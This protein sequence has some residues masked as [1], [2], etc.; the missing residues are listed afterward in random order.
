[1]SVWEWVYYVK[2]VV[3]TA[4]LLKIDVLW[5]VPL[6]VWMLLSPSYITESLNS[7]E[8][9]AVHRAQFVDLTY[10]T[11]FYHFAENTSYGALFELC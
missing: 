9:F 7:R 8:C 10:N 11:I 5:D 4:V 6:V 3:L 2:F 1:V